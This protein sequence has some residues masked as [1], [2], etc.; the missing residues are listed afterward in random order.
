M[1]PAAGQR[2]ATEVAATV[3]TRAQR[4]FAPKDRAQQVV[5]SAE[6]SWHVERSRTARE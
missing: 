6:R 5:L 1:Y 2:R 3:R 4:T